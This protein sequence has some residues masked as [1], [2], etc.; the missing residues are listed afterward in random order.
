[1]TGG[2][3]MDELMAALKQAL[4]DYRQ[5][6]DN[7]EKKRK[8]TD[9][10]LGFGHPLQNDPCHERLDERVDKLIG[11]MQGL[12]PSSQEA[13]QAVRLLLFHEDA[14]WPLAAQWMLR[15]LER[16][17]LPLIPFLA[18]DTAAQ[19][20]KE[21]ASHYKPWDR[22]PVQKQVLKALKEQK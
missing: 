15:A 2:A 7:Y 6:L 1:M 21:Y 13:G 14:A 17:A 3:S 4:A 12:S 20:Q 19:L 10:L 18:P 16:H 9:G 8:P 11:Q 5:D 22:L